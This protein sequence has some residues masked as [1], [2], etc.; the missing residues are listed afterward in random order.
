[1]LAVEEAVRR[2]VVRHDFVLDTRG[3]ERRV[4][5]GVVLRADVLVGSCLEGQDWSLEL[6]S[7]RLE[8]LIDRGLGA[9]RSCSRR[10]SSST[11]T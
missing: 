11:H 2:A 10:P 5:C 3:R 6:G 8:C 1:M 9:V 7:A 4:E